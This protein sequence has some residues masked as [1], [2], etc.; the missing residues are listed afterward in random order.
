MGEY[1]DSKDIKGPKCAVKAGKE[2]IRI[3]SLFYIIVLYLH[4]TFTIII[5]KLGILNV[6]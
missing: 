5:I 2:E 1:G 6:H 3:I 4:N